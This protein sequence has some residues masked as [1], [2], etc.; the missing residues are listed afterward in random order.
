MAATQPPTIYN[1][2][3]ESLPDLN[4]E[5][6]PVLNAHGNSTI[7]LN[8]D[9]PKVWLEYSA[10]TY[11]GAAEDCIIRTLGPS[12]QLN[13]CVPA[14]ELPFHMGT[15]GDVV[16]ATTLYLLHPINQALNVRFGS[17]IICAAEDRGD[18]KL[19]S[20]LIWRYWTGRQ[21]I[22]IAVLELKNRG[23]LVREHWLSA[24]ANTWDVEARIM[25]AYDQDEEKTLLKS[26][27]I[28]LSKQAAAYA[29]QRQV[30]FVALFDWNAMFLYK[31]HAMDPDLPADGVGDCASGTWLE[32][33]TNPTSYRS[34]LFGWL[35]EA[36]EDAGLP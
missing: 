10:R 5:A 20:D 32:T 16:R 34:V 23:M 21:F 6:A 4:L 28:P 1:S 29:L 22:N 14:A 12:P 9:P 36:C 30:R 24:L 27:A 7:A 35:L 33:D 2:F 26:N 3:G 31:Y 15:E 11:S 8:T 13:T 25:R 19:R 18:G 17:R